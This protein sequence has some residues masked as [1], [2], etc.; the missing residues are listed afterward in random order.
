[1]F[2]RRSDSFFPH[3]A[4]ITTPLPNRTLV[5]QFSQIQ[6]FYLELIEDKDYKGKY[7]GSTVNDSKRIIDTYI[8]R[9]AA[10]GIAMVGEKGS[11]KTLLANLVARTMREEHNMPTVLI[12][13]QYEGDSFMQFIANIDVPCV[14]I[15]DEFE[16]HYKIDEQNRILS[17]L[18]G[19]YNTKHLYLITVNEEQKLSNFLQ[20][21]PGR[22][23]YWFEFDGLSAEFI[24]EYCIDNLKNKTYVEEVVSVSDVYSPFNFDM[25]KS[26]VDEMNRY[27][28]SPKQSLAYLNIHITGYTSFSA[29]RIRINGKDITPEMIE[30]NRTMIHSHPMMVDDWVS[31]RLMKDAFGAPSI[32][33]ENDDKIEIN[34]DDKIDGSG[35]ESQRRD[36]SFHLNAESFKSIAPGVFMAT[37]HDEDDVLEL[38][39][40]RFINMSNR[41]K[42]LSA[43]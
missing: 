40:S 12:N 10:T 25:L 41:K 7:Y 2:V 36:Y 34:D 32:E 33:L 6:G 16:K 22:I 9:G 42:S 26:L 1:M 28:E 21:R 5:V 29:R 15:F 35:V 38:E 4:A 27:D 20:S 11:G 31:L 8:D 23:Y 30:T 24:R 13:Q 18:D 43:F 39:Y 3:T 14:V 37:I 19:T 17:L